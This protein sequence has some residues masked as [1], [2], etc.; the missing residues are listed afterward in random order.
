MLDYI[1]T[2]ALAPDQAGRTPNL[3]DYPK[4]TLSLIGDPGTVVSFF[5]FV[6]SESERMHAGGPPWTEVDS[7]RY[8]NIGIAVSRALRAQEERVLSG[9]EPLV[10]PLD[11]QHADVAAALDRTRRSPDA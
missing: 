4:V 11:R 7:D 9:R 1:S 3:G 8:N 10:A 5:Q 6:A 2:V